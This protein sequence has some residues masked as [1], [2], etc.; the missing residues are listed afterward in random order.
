MFIISS[1]FVRQ[2]QIES[3]FEC[4]F[5]KETYKET[6]KETCTKKHR[7]RSD[8]DPV[9]NR[10]SEI[11]T[12]SAWRENDNSFARLLHACPTDERLQSTNPSTGLTSQFDRSA[13]TWQRACSFFLTES[14]ARFLA[15]TVNP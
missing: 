15:G 9:S 13:K 2:E 6:Y 8:F 1:F 14:G 7:R 12:S 10:I 3:G 5:L 4:L 11:Q